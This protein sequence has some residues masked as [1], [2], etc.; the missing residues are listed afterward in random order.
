MSWTI[1]RIKYKLYFVGKYYIEYLEHYC[2]NVDAYKI[3]GFVNVKTNMTCFCNI[4]KP[5]TENINEH[6]T[7]N[8]D[9]KNERSAFNSTH[10]PKCDRM[11]IS[12]GNIFLR[13]QNITT[14]SV[15]KHYRKILYRATYI[16]IAIDYNYIHVLAPSST[17]VA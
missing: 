13:N 3:G 6:V 9:V 2:F 14:I 17:L 12:P 15:L 1:D 16:S 5:I 8:G 10:S 7:M 4:E 11:I